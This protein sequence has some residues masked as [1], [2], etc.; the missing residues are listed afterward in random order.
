[1]KKRVGQII[2]ESRKPGWVIEPLAK[3]LLRSYR[4]QT[5]RFFWAKS[6]KEAVKSGRKIGYPVVVK[7]VSEAVIHK[8]DVKGVLVGI[9]DDAQLMEAYRALSRIEGFAGILIDE[10]VSGTELIIGAKNDPQFGPVVLT[11]IGGTSVEIYRDVSILMAPVAKEAALDAISSLR[12]AGLLKG[13]RGAEPVNL[14]RL[15]D[16]VVSFSEMAYDL[17]DVVESIDLNPVI[18][19]SRDAVI[20]DARIILK[21]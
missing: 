15:S 21:K 11:G 8:S 3:E 12:G 6:E 2:D 4:L 5:S 18:C 19:N 1:M 16:L 9:G 10:M 20:A 14:D 17:R 7:I 13:Y